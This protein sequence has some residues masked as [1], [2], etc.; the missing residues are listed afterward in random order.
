MRR[1]QR[2]CAG[3]GV[4]VSVPAQDHH[5][6]ASPTTVVQGNRPPAQAWSQGLLGTPLAA[7]NT[8]AYAAPKHSKRDKGWSG[9][10]T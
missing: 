4:C 10:L 5:P 6:K 1:A 2:V 3:S 8:K 7:C 9:G